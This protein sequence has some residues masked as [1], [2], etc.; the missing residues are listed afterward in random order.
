MHKTLLFGS[1]STKK[2]LAGKT[3]EREDLEAVFA[4]IQQT[5]KQANKRYRSK[6]NKLEHR[7]ICFL[8]CISFSRRQNFYFAGPSSAL[9][10]RD[11]SGFFRKGADFMESGA[12]TAV[13]LGTEFPF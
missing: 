13:K 2:K 10:L 7:T 12:A 4:S 5:N 1:L 6:E 8:I 9:T 11:L 3:L